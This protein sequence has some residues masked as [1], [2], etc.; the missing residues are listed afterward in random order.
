MVAEGAEG[1]VRTEGASLHCRP[2]WVSL[3]PPL[4]P[5]MLTRFEAREKLVHREEI[6]MLS[7]PSKSAD[8]FFSRQKD[9]F[10]GRATSEGNAG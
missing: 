7:S 3:C 2:K 6:R 10:H 5:S 9:G 8:S 1:V 4:V